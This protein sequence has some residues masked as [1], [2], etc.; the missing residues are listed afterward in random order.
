MFIFLKRKS[1]Q[2]KKNSLIKE[3][4]VTRET[5]LLL[6]YYRQWVPAKQLLVIDNNDYIQTQKI[7]VDHVKKFLTKNAF[8]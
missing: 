7:L 3:S 8:L 2:I 6:S 5:K 1:V 4:T